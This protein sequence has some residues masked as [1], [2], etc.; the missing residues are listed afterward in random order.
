VEQ[1]AK[2]NPVTL[3]KVED[4]PHFI[5]LFAPNVFKTSVTQFLQNDN[6]VNKMEDSNVALKS[7]LGR[8]P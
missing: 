7:V 5:A 2:N 3:V 6:L 1:L 4:A 8:I